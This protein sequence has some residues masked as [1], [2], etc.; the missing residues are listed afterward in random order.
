MVD[1]PA[2]PGG[3]VVV[4]QV[5]TSQLH[6]GTNTRGMLITIRTGDG[7]TGELF[8][9]MADYTLEKARTGLI[10]LA[11]TLHGIAAG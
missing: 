11:A 1:Q 6:N 5:P 9:P 3:Y 8:L 7:H 2:G 4:G 10:E